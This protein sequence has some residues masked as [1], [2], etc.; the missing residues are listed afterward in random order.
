MIPFHLQDKIQTR[1]NVNHFSKL[2]RDH[3]PDV[4]SPCLQKVREDNGFMILLNTKAR[5]PWLLPYY[6]LPRAGCRYR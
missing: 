6:I 4:R 2:R 1:Q 3:F 5:L